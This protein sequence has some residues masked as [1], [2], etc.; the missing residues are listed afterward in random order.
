[1]RKK[2]LN[3]RPV[4]LPVVLLLVI[5]G[6][7]TPLQSIYNAQVNIA[8]F[9]S[10]FL[11]WAVSNTHKMKKEW[12]LILFTIIIS[13]MLTMAFNN[14]QDIQHYAGII[15]AFMGAGFLAISISRDNFE[16]VFIRFMTIVAFYSLIITLYSNINLSFPGTLPVFTGSRTGWR[17]ISIFYYYWGWNP[18][19]RLVRNAACFREPGV[20]GCYSCL[21]LMFQIKRQAKPDERLKNKVKRNELLRTILLVLG[22]ISSLSTTAI[23]CLGLCLVFYLCLNEKLT[24]KSLIVVIL[25][26]I[27]GAIVLQ[28][29]ADLLF[30]KFNQTSNTYVSLAERMDGMWAGIRSIMR[31]PILGSG[32]TYYINNT[33]GTSANAYVDI[34]GKYGIFVFAIVMVGLFK[35]VKSYHINMISRYTIY[36]LL[37]LMLGTQN[38]LIYPIFLTLAMY[39]LTEKKSSTV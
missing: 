4:L 14:D 23:L 6:S 12:M 20:W 3:I 19:T 30:S 35:V 29:Q 25:G 39:G 1:M 33:V 36:V 27:I 13:L 9:V 26:I 21:A 28:T 8:L 17:H 11:L 7:G 5:E 22:V 31:N 15:L 2:T 24:G 16:I 37:L 18:W 32:Y 34:W 10:S 38:L